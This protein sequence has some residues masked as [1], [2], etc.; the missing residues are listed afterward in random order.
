[1]VLI[2]SMKK[3]LVKSDTGITTI[4]IINIES[5]FVKVLT[6]SKRLK[7]YATILKYKTK[8]TKL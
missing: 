5:T 1:M 7:I 3:W 6:G 4:K 2:V 8:N